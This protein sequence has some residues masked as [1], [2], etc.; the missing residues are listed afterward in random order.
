MDGI[1]ET[2]VMLYSSKNQRSTILR[3]LLSLCFVLGKAKVSKS[4]LDNEEVCINP[5]EW[6]YLLP[7]H[8]RVDISEISHGISIPV[9]W[10]K[11]T[12]LDF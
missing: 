9:R 3:V 12:R 4:T 2:R 6:S 5:P 7:E 1:D 11:K 10:E 8:Q